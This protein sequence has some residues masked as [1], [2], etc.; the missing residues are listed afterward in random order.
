MRNK[1]NQMKS[2]YI[3]LLIISFCFT[4]LSLYEHYFHYFISILYFFLSNYHIIIILLEFTIN[5]I[6]LYTQVN[7]SKEAC[8]PVAIIPSSQ[9][10]TIDLVLTLGWVGNLEH[11]TNENKFSHLSF[12]NIAVQGRNAVRHESYRSLKNTISNLV[13]HVGAFPCRTRGSVP[14]I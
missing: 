10:I 4:S 6:T 14:S 9:M 13:E 12:G 11:S 7:P 3:E 8:I 2:N 1:S 5:Y